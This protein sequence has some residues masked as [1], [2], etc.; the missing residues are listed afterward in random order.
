[1]SKQTF[2]PYLTQDEISHIISLTQRDISNPLSL[3]IY[4]KCKALTIKIS[5]QIV[6]PA[7]TI[8][9]TSLEESL[10]F[11]E[12]L[13]QNVGALVEEMYKIWCDPPKRATL[14]LS[15]LLLVAEYRYTNDL[16]TPEEEEAYETNLLS[17]GS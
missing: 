10:G 3:S 9:R 17:N 7:Y 11:S 1:M 13:A 2:R 8:K 15:E 6:A 14:T 12:E 16:M 4:K 5:E